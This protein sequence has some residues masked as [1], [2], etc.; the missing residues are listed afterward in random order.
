MMLKQ[1]V[2]DH[3][4]SEAVCD[5]STSEPLPAASLQQEVD[6][7]LKQ[8]PDGWNMPSATCLQDLCTNT[9]LLNCF[10]DERVLNTMTAVL[11]EKVL[12]DI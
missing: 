3:S 5:C 6:Q 8:L 10:T 9:Q 4:V 11:T 7:N 1:S 2:K 12:Q